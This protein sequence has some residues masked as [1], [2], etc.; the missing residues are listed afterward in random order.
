M[1]LHDLQHLPSVSSKALV[2]SRTEK[3]KHTP[4]GFVLTDIHLANL[5]KAGVHRVCVPPL[6]ATA[7]G[8][9]ARESRLVTP[10]T[11]YPHFE[12]CPV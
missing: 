2:S 11:A 4:L 7:R 6:P 5:W 1:L 8:P 10:N 9:A 12:L 3:D